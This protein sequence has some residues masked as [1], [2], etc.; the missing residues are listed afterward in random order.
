MSC[1]PDPGPPRGLSGGYKGQ[2]PREAQQSTPR[3]T[4]WCRF[5]GDE[6]KLVRPRHRLIAGQFNNIAWLNPSSIDVRLA[7]GVSAQPVLRHGVR[8]ELQPLCPLLKLGLEFL[9]NRL[10]LL[11][12]ATFDERSSCRFRADDT[13]AE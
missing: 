12:A 5:L 3:L 8:V 4:C 9:N 6:F 2:H 13:A 7:F 11:D 10:G 1:G